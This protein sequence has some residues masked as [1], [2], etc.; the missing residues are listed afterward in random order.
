MLWR[1]KPSRDSIS[2]KYREQATTE[3]R[4]PLIPLLITLPR[5]IPRRSAMPTQLRRDRRLRDRCRYTGLSTALFLLENGSRVVAL[6]AAKAGFGASGRYEGQSSTA[7]A[8]TSSSAVRGTTTRTLIGA[9]AF[10]GVHIIR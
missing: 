1:L 6:E 3:Y 5:R 2:V 7:T 10:E 4:T 8:V 9:M